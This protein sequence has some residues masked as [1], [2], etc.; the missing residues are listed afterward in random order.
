MFVGDWPWH[1]AI[2]SVNGDTHIYICGGTLVSQN[3]VIT[4]AHCVTIVRTNEP[5]PNADLKFYLGTSTLKLTGDGLQEHR[6][7][8]IIIHPEY[9]PT[10][11]FNDIA[12]IKLDKDVTYTNFVRPICLWEGD[13]DITKIE[14]QAGNVL[15]MTR[16]Q[17]LYVNR[18]L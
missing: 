10:R 13:N 11:L 9:N 7:S 4:A 14:Q 15:D 8:R 5:T 6:P 12:V 2:Y 1:L 16:S 18:L 3:F 17:I